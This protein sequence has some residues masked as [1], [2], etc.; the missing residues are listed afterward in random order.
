MVTKFRMMASVLAAASAATLGACQASTNQP[1]PA[2]TANNISAACV[3]GC[4]DVAGYA[5]FRS[6]LMNAVNARDATALRGLFALDGRM[7]MNGV[8]GDRNSVDWG[9]GG[10][11]A[12]HVWSELEHILTLGCARREDRLYL[13]AMAVTSADEGGDVVIAVRDTL[14]RASPDRAAPVLQRVAIGTSL[15]YDMPVDSDWTRITAT[16]AGQGFVLTK[17]V[18]SPNSTVIE[19]VREGSVWRIQW[20]GGNL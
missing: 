9:L 12:N 18:R 16:E 20:L 7:R 10:D 13:P 2:A 19:L 4:T 14:V 3:D 5:D 15:S 17:D 8:G 6:A 11:N 1:A